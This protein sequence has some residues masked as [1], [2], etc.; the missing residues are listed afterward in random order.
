MIQ[1]TSDA[2]GRTFAGIVSRK[3]FPDKIG[4]GEF[5]G[6]MLM[7]NIQVKEEEA[8]RQTLHMMIKELPRDIMK[9]GQDSDM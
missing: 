8:L 2:S 7:E 6:S 9:Q 4:A 3:G 5:E 1:V